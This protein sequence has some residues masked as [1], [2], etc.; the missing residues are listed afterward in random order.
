MGA[1]Y[2]EKLIW[3]F[4]ENRFF[5]GFTVFV[6]AENLPLSIFIIFSIPLYFLGLFEL[7]PLMLFSL[8][9][10]GIGILL[11]N[12]R[13]TVI[14]SSFLATAGF[15]FAT[16]YN[17][18][19]III[20]IP[21][22]F[23]FYLALLMLLVWFSL[24]TIILVHQSAEFFASTA[25]LILMYGSD[26]NRIFLSPLP[27]LL[28]VGVIGISIYAFTK[29]YDSIFLVYLLAGLISIIFMYSLKGKPIRSAFS[30]FS[31]FLL[32]SLISSYYNYGRSL[33]T[34]YWAILTIFSILYLTQ[35]RA[36]KAVGEKKETLFLMSSLYGFMLALI[37]I[38]SRI[39]VNPE[40]IKA[41]IFLSALSYLISTLLVVTYLKVTGRLAYYVERSKL[42]LKQLL[43]EAT[44]IVGKK[45]AGSIVEIALK[46]VSKLFGRG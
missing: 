36:R 34:V 23:F 2:L 41:W 38:V 5:K 8:L 40:L 19:K 42:D 3:N 43:L 11:R 35:I 44:L 46:G 28:L 4:F 13:Q 7:V 32:Y 24:N 10:V 12:S 6:K 37:L 14:A 27:Q 26:E 1:S 45:A 29:F 20:S 39:M 33:N 25:G 30:I 21:Y 9:L 18:F 22:E 16:V 17:F 31:F 15:L